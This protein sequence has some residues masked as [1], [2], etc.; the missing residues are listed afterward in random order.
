MRNKFFV[1]VNLL[2]IAVAFSLCTIA[3]FNIQFNH[4]FNASFDDAALI[5]KVNAAKVTAEGNQLMGISPLPLAKSLNGDTDGLIATSY[6]RKNE[7]LRLDDQLF[8]ESV[9]YADDHFFDVFKLDLIAGGTARFRQ[10]TDIFITET[11]ADKLFGDSSAL[12]RTL[13]F[14]GSE[15]RKTP[16]TIAGVLVDLPKNTSFLHTIIAP[17]SHYTNENKLEDTDWSVWVDATFIKSALDKETLNQLLDHYLE[18]Q[19]EVNK[20]MQVAGYQS[21]GL[22]QWSA[23]EGNLLHGN[24]MSN[25]HP[26][27]V[28]G[29]VSSA[30]T[31][32][33]LACFNFINTS[34]AISR[35][36]LREIGVRKVLGG[37]KRDLKIQFLVESLLQ[38]S[39]AMA[40]SGLVTMLLTP[41]Y[42]AMFNFEIVDFSR[43]AWL[44]FLAFATGTWLSSSLLA[45]MYPAF[46]ISRFRPVEIF[47]NKVR[48]SSRNLFTKGLLTFQFVVCVYNLFSMILFT[49]NAQYQETLDRGYAVK[50]SINL[51]LSSPEQFTPLKATLEELPNVVSV[52]G[53]ARAIGFG[54][55]AIAITHLGKDYDVAAVSVGKGY[56]EALQLRLVQGQFFVPGQAANERYVII[57]QMLRDRLEKD[58][59]NEWFTYQGKRFTVLGV[60]EDFNLKPIM[61]DNKIQP[62][63]IFFAPENAY[64]Y[65]NVLV[66][67]DPQQADDIIRA[68]WNTLYP[69]ELYLGFLQEDVMQAV[70]QT[71]NIMMNINGLVVVVTLL[72]SALGLYAM[73]Y[74]NIQSR[75]KEFG[76]RKVLGASVGQILYLLNRQV[77]IMLAIASVLGVICGDLVIGKIM[78]IVYA[79]H[80]DIEL[81]NY[82]WPVLIIFIIAF[83]AIGFRVYRSARQN[84]V[85][86]LRVE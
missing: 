69:D 63:V 16:F 54:T 33:L 46:Y 21:V 65:A 14:V 22:L 30:I 40:L 58:V 1:G 3:Y 85:E 84:P 55:E 24:F 36:R 6:H 17:L 50:T 51:P 64:H 81:N 47:K 42:N 57:N 82:L 8:R 86:Q 2:S 49:Q 74:M 71:N 59:L 19:N 67:D 34:I 13:E 15:G 38:M 23:L 77:V 35:N 62:T 41:A 37:R 7:L 44:P 29:T 60:V 4:S 26:A 75:I 43:V 25:L 32:L 79:Y 70:R 10:K 28:L 20:S 52:T 68:A 11:L 12:G 9:G 48:F 27:S 80:K 45:G 56:L 53:T 73:V 18:P 83:A 78:D 39:F 76:V 5:H 61:L 31:V 72:I 66:S